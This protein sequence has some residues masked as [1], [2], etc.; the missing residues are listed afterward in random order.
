MRS[1]IFPILAL[2]AIT[3]LAACG[4]EAEEPAVE[5]PPVATEPAPAPTTAVPVAP[6]NA[7]TIAQVPVVTVPVGVDTGNAAPA[8]TGTATTP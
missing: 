5:A 2:G 4:D 8:G 7:D 6:V 1:R 3:S